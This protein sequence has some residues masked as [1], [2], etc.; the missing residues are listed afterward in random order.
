MTGQ[1]TGEMTTQT[2]GHK[3]KVIHA[4]PKG[5][6]PFWYANCLHCDWH[7]NSFHDGEAADPEGEAM[8]EAEGH[9]TDGAF[10][11]PQ[12]GGE[13]SLNTNDP[14]VTVL[15]VLL[16]DRI[17]PGDIEQ[18]VHE[19]EKKQTFPAILTNKFVGGYAQNLAE[20]IRKIGEP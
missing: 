2:N 20:R 19:I 16:R 7:S 9:E 8:N 15:Y 1:N 6:P 13:E 14:L 3:T 4:E 18:I 12:M 17:H 10:S 11:L 5:E